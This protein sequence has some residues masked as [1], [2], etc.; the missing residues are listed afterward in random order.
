MV[1]TK[2]QLNNLIKQY[3][4]LEVKSKADIKVLVKEVKS[5]RRSQTELTQKLSSTMKEK[6]EA[7]VDFKLEYEL[8]VY[9]AILEVL[10]FS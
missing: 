10:T 9:S 2:E 1:S 3:E 7:E 8:V 6:S 4:D 5:L